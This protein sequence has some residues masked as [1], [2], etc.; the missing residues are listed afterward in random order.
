MPAPTLPSFETDR[1]HLRPRTMQ[2]FDACLAMDR[3]PLV[4]R[5]ITGPW[6]DAEAHEGF[7]RDRIARDFGPGLGYWSFFPKAEPGRFAGWILL[8]PY[9]GIGPEIDI[10]W[11]L[12][13][14]DWGKGFATEAARPIVHHAFET[15]GLARVVAD[16]DPRNQPSMHVAEKIGMKFIGEGQHDGQPCMSYV[17]TR[18]DF[19]RSGDRGT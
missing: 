15:I 16:I 5:Y 19:L 14:A 8:I 11:R 13:R 6:D 1:L 7:L 4:T 9:D 10:G 12:T 18:D 3:D 2:D 17:M